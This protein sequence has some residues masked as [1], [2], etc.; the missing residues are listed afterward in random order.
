MSNP[1]SSNY[2]ATAVTT[3][4]TENFGDSKKTSTFGAAPMSDTKIL[5]KP[6]DSEPTRY[7][8][9]KPRRIV[10]RGKISID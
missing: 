8:L 3:G 5:P 4:A 1:F 7:V 6:Y 2:V 10:F 9:V